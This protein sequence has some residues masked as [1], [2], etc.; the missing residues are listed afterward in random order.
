M[1][2]PNLWLEPAVAVMNQLRYPVKFLVISALFTIPIAFLMYQWLTQLGTRLD[3][4]ARERVGLEYVVSLRQVMEPLE[5]I[6]V[7]R[8]LADAGDAGARAQLDDERAKL[9]R[10]VGLMDSVNARLGR[11]LQV[12]TLWSDLRPR[13]AHPSVEPTTLLAQAR[14][15]LDQVADTSSLSLDSD[16]DSYQLT[17]A[18]VTRLPALA[19]HLTTVAVAEIA[20][21]LPAG[22]SAAHEASLLAALTQ[23]SAEREALD[24]GHA[25]AFEANPAVRGALESELK[26]SWDAVDV[27]GQLVTARS[28]GNMELTRLSAPAVYGR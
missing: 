1:I 9:A 27:L 4:A 28:D 19:D 10:A 15:S 24:R 13:V 26:G 5:R 3:L 12:R 18:V 25:A 8:L 2:R 16:L 14:R 7:L 22:L 20:R 23:A 21:R 11:E 6:R 17:T